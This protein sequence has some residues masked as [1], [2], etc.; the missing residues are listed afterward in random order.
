MV[1]VCYRQIVE[2]ESCVITSMVFSPC[3]TWLAVG[4]DAGRLRFFDIDG[5]LAYRVVQ[6][7]RPIT[8]LCWWP[9]SLCGSGD[10][11]LGLDD[12]RVFQVNH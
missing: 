9:S 11:L 6:K 10:I 5:R 7:D 4:D 1:Y 12:G 8:S 2:D 3:Q